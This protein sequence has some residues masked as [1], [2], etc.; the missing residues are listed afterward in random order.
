MFLQECHS[1][2]GHPV[3]EKQHYLPLR[4]SRNAHHRQCFQPEQPHD[5][6]AMSAVQDPASQLCSI[7]SEDERSCRSCQQ[8]CEEDSKQDD[9]DVQRLARAPALCFVCLPNVSEDIRW[10]HPLLSGIRDGSSTA[11]RSGDPFLENP[12]TNSAGRS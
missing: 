11:S 8:K 1:S 12:I 7:P 4:N 9:K 6:L 10:S 2:R 3:C 5:G